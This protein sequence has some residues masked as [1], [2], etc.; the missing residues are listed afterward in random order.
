MPGAYPAYA[1]KT[2]NIANR[3]RDDFLDLVDE[4]AKIPRDVVAL[5]WDY[6]SGRIGQPHRHSRSQLLYAS[7]GVMTVTTEKGVWVVPPL[8]AL[9]LPAY[10]DHQIV[11]AGKLSVRT[12]YIDPNVRRKLPTECCVVSISPLL[13]ELILYAAT[14]PHLYESDSPDERIMAVILD[15]IETLETAPLDLP[16][17]EDPRL[18]QIYQALAE[19]PSDNRTLDDWGAWVGATS[20]TLARLFRAETG[21]SFRQWR[22]QIRILEALRKLGANEPVT[23]VALDL[24]YESPSAFIAMFKRALGTSPGKYFNG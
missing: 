12:L 19:N 13:R 3:T 22:Q 18:L 4:M 23:S 21:M 1:M 6:P 7:V 10:T 5:S 11:C 17:P 20:R 16:V 24:G 9:W 8:R 2:L 14:L 15:S